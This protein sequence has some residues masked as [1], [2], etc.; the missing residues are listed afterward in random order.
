MISAGAVAKEGIARKIGDRNSDSPK[1]IAVVTDVRPVLPPSDTP[2]AL[3]TNVVVVDVPRTAPAVVAIASARSASLIRGS[4]PSLS[5]ISALVAH[6]IKVPSVSKMSTK[7]NA[8]TI[9][10]KSNARRLEK[11]ALKHC[12]K[13]EEIAPRLKLLHAG[14]RE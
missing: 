5:S 12:P 4:F 7:R 8:H 11:S 10:T 2:D 9:A 3:S 13:T 14:I 6:P 1:R